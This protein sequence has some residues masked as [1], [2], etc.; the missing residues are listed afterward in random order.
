MEKNSIDL[1]L[2]QQPESCL[3]ESKLDEKAISEAFRS[4]SNLPF[5][6]K[7]FDYHDVVLARILYM[8]N[9]KG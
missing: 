8:E 7:S 9:T 2:E 5:Y 1:V 3:I 4:Y 6:I